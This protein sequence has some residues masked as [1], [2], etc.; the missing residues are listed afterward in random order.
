MLGLG[1][2]PE[3]GG[4]EVVLLIYGGRVKAGEGVDVC[5]LWKEEG[6]GVGVGKGARKLVFERELLG[7]TDGLLDGCT[8]GC[9]CG[10]AGKVYYGAGD[11]EIRG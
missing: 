7:G 2:G 8:G 6:G 10:S 9:G 5:R 11:G 1:L 4:G 3:I